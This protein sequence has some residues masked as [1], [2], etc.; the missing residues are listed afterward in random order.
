DDESGVVVQCHGAFSLLDGVRAVARLADLDVVGRLVAMDTGRQVGVLDGAGRG[1]PVGL[2]PRGGHEVGARDVA[3][4]GEDLL[5]Q[6]GV[7]HH[8]ADGLG[9]DRRVFV[10]I[11]VLAEDVHGDAGGVEEAGVARPRP[12]RGVSTGEDQWERLIRLDER[13][14]LDV[15]KAVAE[16]REHEVFDWGHLGERSDRRGY[17]GHQSFLLPAFLALIRTFFFER[18]GRRFLGRWEASVRM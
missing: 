9:E 5:G 14:H 13:L 18:T 8:Y 1:G 17:A 3:Q 15:G 11:R 6:P 2:P 7:T 4:A 16:D 12:E 10:P